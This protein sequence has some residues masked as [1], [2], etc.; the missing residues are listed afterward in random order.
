MKKLFTLLIV[1]FAFYQVN[2]QSNDR[3][4]ND[5]SQEVEISD[6]D[7]NNMESTFRI[8]STIKAVDNLFLSPV[9]VNEGVLIIRFNTPPD[10]NVR[11]RI[12]NTSGIQVY[13]AVVPSFGTQRFELNVSFLTAGVYILMADA[14]TNSQWKKFIVQ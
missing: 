4:I 8:R 5:Q 7:H 3:A 2:A 1:C 14:G 12:I 6:A 13:S 11:I 10:V 9:P